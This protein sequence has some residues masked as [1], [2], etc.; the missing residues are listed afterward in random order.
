MM[1]C[2]GNCVSYLTDED[3]SGNVTEFRHDRSKESGFCALRDLFYD[4]EK[5]GKPC[6]E[7][8][9]DKEDEK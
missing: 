3:G 5:N 8:A 4:V 2:C 6:G 9:Y 7:Y 1:P